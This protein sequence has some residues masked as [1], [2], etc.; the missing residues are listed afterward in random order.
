[1][2]QKIEAATKKHMKEYEEFLRQ[3]EQ[4]DAA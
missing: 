1:M 3:E 4:A 2:K